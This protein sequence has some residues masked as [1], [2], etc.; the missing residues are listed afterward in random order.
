MRLIEDGW[1]LHL[2]T[3]ALNNKP[4]GDTKIYAK[5]TL[6]LPSTF[7]IFLPYFTWW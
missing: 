1:K 4:Y 3:E 6:L 7:E 2:V 5:N